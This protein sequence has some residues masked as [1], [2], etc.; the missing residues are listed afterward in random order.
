MTSDTF[1]RQRVKR[2]GESRHGN[3]Q[4]L[5]DDETHRFSW[6]FFLRGGRR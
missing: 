3:S 5:T 1:V 6:L 4:V 2:I